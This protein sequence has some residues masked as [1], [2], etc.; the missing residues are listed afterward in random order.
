MVSTQHA[1]WERIC[2]A[3]CQVAKYAWWGRVFAKLPY[4]AKSFAK[5]LEG[6]FKCFCQKLRMPTP[7]AKLLEMLGY[8]MYCDRISCLTLISYLYGK[9]WEMQFGGVAW[10]FCPQKAQEST[11]TGPL[12]Q[13]FKFFLWQVWTTNLHELSSINIYIIVHLLQQYFVVVCIRTW[14]CKSGWSSA[15]SGKSYILAT[16]CHFCCSYCA[17]NEVV[18][19]SWFG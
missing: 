6:C 3:L 15:C 4:F 8:P 11:W 1:S 16:S 2:Q 17:L 19:L 18:I 14:L 12:R 9:R 7:F 5:L 13:S 10:H